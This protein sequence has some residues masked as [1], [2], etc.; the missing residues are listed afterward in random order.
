MLAR[1]GCQVLQYEFGALRLSRSGFSRDDDALVLERPPHQR[2]AVVAD[3]ED[4]RRKFAN[5]LL[6]VHLDL[7]RGVDRKDLVRVHSHQ[8]GTGVSLEGGGE[9]KSGT[10]SK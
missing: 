6:L 8:D 7:V 4:V 2:V 9:Q 1:N 5:L 3:G 10:S